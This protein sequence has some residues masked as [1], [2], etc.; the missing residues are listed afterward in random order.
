MLWKSEYIVIHSGNAHIA[1]HMSF[2]DIRTV[3]L[4]IA[5]TDNSHDRAANRLLRSQ[6][7]INQKIPLFLNAFYKHFVQYLKKFTTITEK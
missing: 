1:L 6:L 5:K 3:W 4:C 7:W 2:F